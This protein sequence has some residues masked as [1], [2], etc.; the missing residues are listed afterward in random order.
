MERKFF[1]NGLDIVEMFIERAGENLNR[2]FT[3]FKIGA[4]TPFNATKRL[5]GILKNFDMFT[6]DRG[7]R[8]RSFIKHIDECACFVNAG[9]GD[10]AHG[11]DLFEKE[12]C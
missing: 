5:R 4:E 7:H 1:S 6:R 10:F 12:A 11:F 9:R 2:R 3:I 8:T